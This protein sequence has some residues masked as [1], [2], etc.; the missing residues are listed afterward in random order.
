MRGKMAPS[1]F[2]HRPPTPSVK[3]SWLREVV[4]NAYFDFDNAL[5]YVWKAPTLIEELTKIESKK[6]KRN[7]D[8]ETRVWRWIVETEKLRVFFPEMV[9]HG[10]MFAVC[11]LFEVHLLYLCAELQK[12]TRYRIDGCPGQGIGRWLAYFRRVGV[13]TTK[14]SL[15]PQVAA[16]L[17]IRNCLM[18]AKGALQHSR[19]APEIR[20][21]VARRTFLTEAHRRPSRT[22][23]DSVRV[24]VCSDEIGDRLEISNGYAW[25]AC[26]YLHDYFV[27]L[28]N[29]LGEML[30]QITNHK[31]PIQQK[32][33]PGTRREG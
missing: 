4:G 12:H 23:S 30:L 20:R 7:S 13:D 25:L 32:S 33:P 9:A 21:I 16:A 27:T 17:K 11:S 5:D 29:A 28:G 8:P 2:P 14:L 24:E 1:G 19:D 15:W 31:L 26:A 10:N 6:L 22:K 3:V 18:R